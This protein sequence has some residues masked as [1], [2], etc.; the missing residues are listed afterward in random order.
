MTTT[1][2]TI[3][4]PANLHFTK[5]IRE[6]KEYSI[7]YDLDYDDFHNW[8]TKI[9]DESD[10]DFKT[11]CD[12]VWQG[13]CDRKEK[14]G[15][16]D[17]GEDE[18]EV[19]CDDWDGDEENVCSTDISDLIE[20]EDEQLHPRVLAWREEQRKKADERYE[21]ERLR[22]MEK[23]KEIATLKKRLAELGAV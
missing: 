11:R 19:E 14:N 21:A 17:L 4:M 20:R 1:T 15:A 22:R 2:T 3:K 6:I 9:D 13:L 12:A 5:T 10:E 8:M 16:I 18:D 23:Q 7:S